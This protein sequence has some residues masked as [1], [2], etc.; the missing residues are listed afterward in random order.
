[1]PHADAGDIDGII[2]SLTAAI[3]DVVAWRHMPL[4]PR[5]RR[6]EDDAMI[7]DVLWRDAWRFCRIPRRARCYGH[8]ISLLGHSAISCHD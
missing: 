5:I 3:F 2:S 7:G 1:M 6:R 4:S 8:F